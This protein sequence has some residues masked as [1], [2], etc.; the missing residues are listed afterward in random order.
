MH[1]Q[2]CRQYSGIFNG[3]GRL[4]GVEVKLHIHQ[5]V[6]PVAQ[7]ARRIP[8]HMRKKVARELDQLEQ[9]GII[10]KVDGPTPWVSPLVI[11]PKKSGDVRIC[12]DMRMANRAINRERHPTPTIDDLIHTLNGATVFSKLDLRAGYHQLTLAPESRYI[13]TFATHKGLRR[14]ARLNFGTNSAS[15]IFQMVIN[16]L[17]RDIPEALNISDDVI[18]FGK[19]QAEHDAALQAVFRKFAEVNLTLNKKKCEFNKKSIT[20]FGFVFSGQGISPDPKK[21]EAIKNAKPPT[22]TSGVRSFLGMAT[23]C[24]KFIPNFS[25]TSEPL[26]ELTKMPNFNGVSDMSNHSTRSKSYS[27]VP[28]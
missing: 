5:S 11:T 13:T 12:V 21:V 23:Y 1:E 8:F 14:Y 20:F 3:I 19:T 7:R 17:I 2:L 28:R 24:A 15:E 25:D 16:E 22:T 4:K 9:Q 27:P 6:P 10:E 26:R 18:V